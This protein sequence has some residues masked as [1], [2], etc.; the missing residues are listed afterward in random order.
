[1][2]WLLSFTVAFVWSVVVQAKSFTGNRLLV[3]LEEQA[4]KE[5]YSVF[6]EDLTCK[7]IFQ[8]LQ[9]SKNCLLFVCG[10]LAWTAASWSFEAISYNLAL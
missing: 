7:Y 1:M 10:A 6:L 2:R 9:P 5:K 8:E 3:V 4:E